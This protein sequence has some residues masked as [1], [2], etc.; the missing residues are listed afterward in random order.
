M[1]GEVLGPDETSSSEYAT[2]RGDTG[3]RDL[4]SG[5]GIVGRQWIAT[6]VALLVSGSCRIGDYEF[7]L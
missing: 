6:F 2:F 7:H 4:S 3:C 5:G 1:L